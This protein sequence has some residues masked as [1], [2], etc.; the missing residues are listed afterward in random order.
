MK[1]IATALSMLLIHTATAEDT[2]SAIPETPATLPEDTESPTYYPTMPYN[3]N[4]TESPTYY[5][6][7]YDDKY[8]TQR[9]SYLRAATDDEIT[10][11]PT[12][13]PTAYDDDESSSES[14]T[15]YPLL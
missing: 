3:Y 1:V 11:S 10:D 7:A 8:F 9:T 14:P 4:S 12:Y 6:T 5:P 15:Y 2:S 13:Y